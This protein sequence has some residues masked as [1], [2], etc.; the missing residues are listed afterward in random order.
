MMPDTELLTQIVETFESKSLCLEI[1]KPLLLDWMQTDDIE[2][3]GAIYSFVMEPVCAHRIQPGLTL[4]EYS[5]FIFRYFGYCLRL[6]P[7]G[8]WSHTRYEAGWDLARWFAILWR[9]RDV[10]QETLQ[11]IK[12]WLAKLYK[13]ENIE[14]RVCIINATLEHLFENRT[15]FRFFSD[16]Q[17]DPDLAVAYTEARFWYVS[18]PG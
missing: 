1:P 13:E 12:Y 2:V 8:K 5:E 15:I 16:W 9:E 17:Q 7:E 14:V 11:Q 4:Q 10:Y 18:H 6:N 3:L